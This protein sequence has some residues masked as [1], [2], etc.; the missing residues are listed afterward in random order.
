MKHVDRGDA[1]GKDCGDCMHYI[2]PENAHDAATCRIVDGPINPHGHCLAF[3][4]KARPAPWEPPQAP[5]A[6]SASI[7]ASRAC[8]CARSA[9][10]NGANDF[11]STRSDTARPASST[12]SPSGVR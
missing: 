11:A 2:A 8:N 6:S 5:G 10:F 3:T 9:L 7:L 12:A 4:A 1:P